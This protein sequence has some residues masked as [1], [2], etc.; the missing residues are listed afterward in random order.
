MTLVLV[1][2]RFLQ[3]CHPP[4]LPGTVDYWL[5]LH[6]YSFVLILL[7]L[8]RRTISLDGLLICHHL[9]QWSTLDL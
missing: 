2:V 5:S 6:F 8:L 4:P 1:T 7:L 3:Y 9:S